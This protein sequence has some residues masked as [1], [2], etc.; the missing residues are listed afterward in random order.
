M[1]LVLNNKEY[2]ITYCNTFF[3]RL[4]GLMFTK[5]VTEQILLFPRCNSVHTFFMFQNI[6]I[7][8]T[9]KN[10]NIKYK[11]K[12]VSPWKIIFPKKN[13]YYTFEFSTCL[14]LNLDKIKT[15]QIKM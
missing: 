10:Y 9:D 4:K 7:I 5:K 6:D 13:I 3:K 8:M 15:L 2:E 1:K 14:N 12:E 11:F